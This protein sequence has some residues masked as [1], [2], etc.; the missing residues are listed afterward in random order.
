MLITATSGANSESIYAKW[1]R[2][3]MTPVTER[4][5]AVYVFCYLGKGKGIVHP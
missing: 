5:N 1:D 4:K 3:H 2:E